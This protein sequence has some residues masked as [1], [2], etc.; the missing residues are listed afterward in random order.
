MVSFAFET[1][2]VFEEVVL[3]LNSL[4]KVSDKGETFLVLDM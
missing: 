2:E 3:A 1:V 4:H